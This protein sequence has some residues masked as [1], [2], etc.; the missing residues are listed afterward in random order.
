MKIVH[1][2]LTAPYEDGWG[3][4]ENIIS[5][6]HKRLGNDVTIITN[7][8]LLTKKD[9]EY[10]QVDKGIT[11]NQ[12]GI[13]VVRIDFLL[14]KKDIHY[15]RMYKNLIPAIEAE[16]PD[17]LFVH[18]GQFVDLIK[19]KW[20]MKK[21]TKTKL[22]ID[23][24]ADFS[25]SARTPLLKLLHKVLWR[26]C[27]QSIDPYVDVYYGVL[28]A[29]VDFLIDMYKVDPKKVRLL[30]MGAD[31][32][33][34]IPKNERNGI[35]KKY[36]IHEDEFV[37]LT[38][39]KIDSS[40]RECL[41]LMDAVNSLSEKNRRVKLV[42]F[43]SVEDDIMESFEKKLND[44][45]AYVGWK[46]QEELYEL[47]SMADLAVFPGRHSV[48]WEQTVASKTPC[49]FKKWEGTTHVDLGGNCL[50]VENPS[51]ENLTAVL[52][53]IF[54]KKGVYEEM[55]HIANSEKANRFLY[56]N[57]AKVSLEYK[58]ME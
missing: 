52:E 27:I 9:G 31:D 36:G 13:K 32:D 29:R 17:V 56:S 21:H 39:G 48:I 44:S 23:N 12:D 43:G 1:L 49:V 14:G 28:P 35:R 53:E 7:R 34:V 15:F 6:Y 47:L 19:V 18:G 20:Y 3:Y 46:N 2:C 8:L 58:E 40:K 42:V 4:Q 11:V 37:I 25:N 54:D 41:E 57:I 55:N 51:T 26:S 5:K 45:I 22:I 16:D 38:G 30:V 10:L 33:Y 50:F 24:H